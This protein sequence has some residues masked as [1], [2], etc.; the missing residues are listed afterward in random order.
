MSIRNIPTGYHDFEDFTRQ[1]EQMKYRVVESNPL[2]GAAT[3]AHFMSWFPQ[4]MGPLVK[5]GIHGIMD[6]NLIVAFGCPKPRSRCVEP[7]S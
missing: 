4:W 3:R 1:T 7:S 6:E 5:C 2:V